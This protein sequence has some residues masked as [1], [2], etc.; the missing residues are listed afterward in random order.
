MY[1]LNGTEYSLEQLQSAAKVHSM[2]FD[3]YMDVMKKKGLVEKTKDVAVQD[4]SVA[5]Q[6]DMASSSET[7][8]SVSQQKFSYDPDSFDTSV[9]VTK[10]FK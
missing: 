9:A 7:T 8:S 1:E 3:S 10:C 6:N 5:S 2:D 4:A